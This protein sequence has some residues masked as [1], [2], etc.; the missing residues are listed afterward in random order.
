[1]WQFSAPLLG[2]TV[3]TP[4]LT[5][6]VVKENDGVAVQRA[7]AIPPRRRGPGD[8]G[9][10]C[11]TLVTRGT[12]AQLPTTARSSVRCWRQRGRA[13]YVVDVATGKLLREFGPQHF[14]SPLTSAVIADGT[15]MAAPW[16]PILPTRTASCGG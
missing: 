13:L 8:R 1:M 5:Q 16:Q 15:D 12:R 14:P 2:N 6:A 7:I 11:G 4:A 3:G 10:N 9:G